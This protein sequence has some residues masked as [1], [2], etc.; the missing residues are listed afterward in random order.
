MKDFLT[1]GQIINIHGIKGELKVF[2]LTDDSKRYRKLKT[3]YIDGVERKILWCKLQAK[4]VVLKIEGIETPEEAI[5]YRDK[6]L[7]VKR[8]DA[9]KLEEDTYFVA[10]IIGCNVVDENNK[11]LGKVFDVIF[12]GSNEVYWVK[13]KEELMVPALKSVV[14]SMDLKNKL[15]T[16]KPVDSWS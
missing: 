3:V 9:V 6:Y 4:F 16:I 12:T 2:P 7:E 10:D 14:V 8:D 15:V 11:E 5:K 1:I 13:G